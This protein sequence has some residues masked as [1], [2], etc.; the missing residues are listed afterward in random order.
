MIQCA[1]SDVSACFIHYISQLR[2]L[3][4]EAKVRVAARGRAGI[5]LESPRSVE[6]E[7]ADDGGRLTAE[8]TASRRV[9][10]S[11]ALL[12]PDKPRQVRSQTPTIHSATE[13]ESQ[14]SCVSR[15]RCAR[16]AAGTRLQSY[17]TMT[18]AGKKRLWVS[19]HFG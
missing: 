4:D 2:G 15:G 11:P 17:V 19:E 6:R 5:A 7:L 18:S 12:K 1:Q 8:S 14:E 10:F 16:A 3:P 13:S 9:A